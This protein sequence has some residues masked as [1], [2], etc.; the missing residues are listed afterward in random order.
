MIDSIDNVSNA[1]L[2]DFYQ[3]SMAYGF[4]KS[5]MDKKETVFHLF[6][7]RAPFQGNYCISCGLENVISFIDTLHFSS[8]DLDYLSSLEGND[9]KPLFEQG[10]L[11]YLSNLEFNCDIDAVPEG[12]VVF[13]LEPVIRIKGPVIQCQLLETPLLNLM[14]FPTLIATKAAR[15]CRAA[16][17]DPVL[18]F[19]LRRAQGIDGAITASRSAFIGGCNATSNVLA[20]KRYG[21]PVRGTIAHSWVMAFDDELEAFETYSNIMPN[22]CV[23]LV[24]TYST[25]D[26]IKKAIETG[27][28]LKKKGYELG[29]IRLDSGDLAYLSTKAREMLDEAGFKDARIVASN[30]LDETIIQSLKFQ[31]AKIDVWGVGTKL[32]TAYNQPALDGVYKL[33]AIRNPGGE[34]E[35]KIKISEQSVKVTTPGVH[36]VRRYIRDNQYIGDVIYDINTD[37]EEGCLMID[38]FDMTRQKHIEAGVPHKDLLVPIYD[39]GVLVYHRPT[40]LEIKEKV[41][42][43]IASFHPTIMRLI[44]PHNYPVGNEK[45]LND[46]KIDLTLKARKK[47]SLR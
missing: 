5:G 27:K 9:G 22:D 42:Q 13:P 37:M 39:K 31:Q 16:Q 46:L 10:F 26:G 3:L 6:F 11:D 19:G 34:W 30:D 36:Q 14:N 18:E 12:T 28:K 35:Y 45:S 38:P 15:I 1:I 47:K 23:L 21:I 33:S 7:R 17:G 44:N 43:E 4:W 41:K 29:G 8:E 32:V 2:T 20:G 24:D 25:I 40:I